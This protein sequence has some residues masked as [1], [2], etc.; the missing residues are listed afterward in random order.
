MIMQH[1]KT[2]RKESWHLRSITVSPDRGSQRQ[3]LAA[4]LTLAGI[5]IGLSAAALGSVVPTTAVIWASL[6]LTTWCAG[7]I[8]AVAAAL[9]SDS[10]GFAR[11]KLGPWMLAWCAVTS[12]LATTAWNPAQPGTAAEITITSVLRALWLI[13]VAMT[14][15]TAGYCIGPRRLAEGGAVRGLKALAGR[16]SNEV[17]S[18]FAPW[19]IYA[20][21]TV[22]RLLTVALTGRLGYVGDAAS[23][24]SSASGY[25]Q[26][27]AMLSMMAPLALAV[28]AFRAWRQN[29]RGA[30]RATIFLFLAEI[31]FS[32]ISGDKQNFVVA[33]IALALPY[34]ASR[35][36]LP[37]IILA[38]A[39]IVFLLLIIP[40]TSVYRGTARGSDVTLTAGE[41]VSGSPA[42]FRQVIAADSPSVLPQSLAYLAQRVQ[43]IDG[44]AILMQRTPGQI[45][46]SSPAELAEAP[47]A[48]L[49]PRAIWHNKPILDTGYE[50][51]QQYYGLPADVY[52]SSAITP[53]GDLYRH[54]GW[55]PVVA[56]MF[57]LGCA[58]RVLDDVLDVRKS[59]HAALLTFLLFPELV[60]AEVD[61]TT[62]LAGVPALMLTWLM[63]VAL[64]FTRRARPQTNLSS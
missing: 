41:A 45:P 34:S 23:T 58:I 16:Y 5:A 64:C 18:P 10:F 24:V 50:F 31:A 13:A 14:A 57:L 51:S 44:P 9:R 11:W 3:R 17:R 8:F 15:W 62:L 2:E 19:V 22:A 61:W 37:K 36:K 48:N 33:I 40:F 26:L 63:V 39:V 52:T 59:C 27:L 29:A 46:F 20:V 28:S 60:K 21:G 30:L 25:Q 12:G 4:C 43:E 42:L 7:L 55:I 53:A 47:L 32:V 49:I 54:G 1:A 56:G 6:A 38:G 35:Q